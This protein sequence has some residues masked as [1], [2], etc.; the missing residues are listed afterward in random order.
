[1]GPAVVLADRSSAEFGSWARGGL[2]W[3]CSLGPRC[4]RVESGALA[5]LSWEEEGSRVL[6][7][8]LSGAQLGPRVSGLNRGLKSGCTRFRVPFRAG[9]K[10]SEL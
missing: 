1:M 6:A 2:A 8:L 9:G 10:G 4:P 7:V 3:R 5:L